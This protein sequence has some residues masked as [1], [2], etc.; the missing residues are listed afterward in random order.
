[1]GILPWQPKSLRWVIVGVS[2]AILALGLS[3]VGARLL[4]PPAPIIDPTRGGG[5]LM[6]VDQLNA[7]FDCC[8]NPSQMHVF[9][10]DVR[11]NVQLPLADLAVESSGSSWPET[12]ARW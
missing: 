4:H 5:G 9:G 3:L 7:S 11:S 10:F 2:L 1:P 8:T 12:F 6:V